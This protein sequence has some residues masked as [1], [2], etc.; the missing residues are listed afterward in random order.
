MNRI[1]YKENN[2]IQEGNFIEN[3]AKALGVVA[4]ILLAIMVIAMHIFRSTD[5]TQTIGNT[6]NRNAN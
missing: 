1:K 3:T 5:V 4:T 2:Y 6:C